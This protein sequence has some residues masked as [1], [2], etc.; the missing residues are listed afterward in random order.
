[1]KYDTWNNPFERL[2]LTA[3]EGRLFMDPRVATCKGF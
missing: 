2:A 1:M 3:I